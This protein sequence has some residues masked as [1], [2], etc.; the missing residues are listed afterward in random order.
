MIDL[1]RLSAPVAAAAVALLAA[2][3]WAGTA[4]A[5]TPGVRAAGPVSP[6]NDALIGVP[7]AAFG[8]TDAGPLPASASVAVDF[9][10]RYRHADELERDAALVSTPGSPYYR[11]FLSNAQWNAYFAPGTQ[12]VQRV[13]ALLNRAGFRIA[14]IGAN[15]GIVKAVAPTS[16]VERYFNT[17]LR[18]ALQ[19]GRGLKYR[20]VTPAVIPAELAADVLAVTGLDSIETIRLKPA[21]H[22][23]PES[24]SA[25]QARLASQAPPL[26]GPGGVNELGPAVLLTG[27]SYPTGKNGK[28][29]TIGISVPDGF[30]AS[31][32][33]AY[34]KYFQITQTGKVTVVPINGGYKGGPQGEGTLDVESISG[35][36]PAADV[37]FYEWPDFSNTSILD[38]FN[39]IVSDDAVSSVSNSWG[40]AENGQPASLL[41]ASDKI[42]LQAVMKGIDFIFSSGDAGAEADGSSV[43]AAWPADDPNVTTLG[44]VHIKV[45]SS[46]G[47]IVF[48]TGTWKNLGSGNN[49]RDGSGGGVS[50]IYPLPSYQSQV[51][52]STTGRNEPDI[53]VVGDQEDANYAA[54]FGGWYSQGG[55]SWS[56]PSFNALLAD[57]VSETGKKPGFVNPT[58]Y[59][60]YGKGPAAFVT[61]V[62]HGYNGIDG[63]FGYKAVKGYDLVTGF[64][65]PVGTALLKVL[66]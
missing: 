66:Q 11:Q 14:S 16:V 58:L 51:A 6:T 45:N 15:R 50:K 37:L 44:G 4:S 17:T 47:A 21:P 53:S 43:V 23:V 3:S 38:S 62:V 48:T 35:L 39:T 34:L 33:A 13:T 18:A 36:A 54:S 9:V 65:T 56:A 60:A 10:L 8:V 57:I 29:A 1:S 28:G 32:T 2:P 31:D 49:Y 30:V 64:G 46:T 40:G 59:K 7:G 22:G 41:K 24:P 52:I 5:A 55:T 25:Q 12:S 19:P 42:F 61:D 26:F 20:N 63:L 27:Y